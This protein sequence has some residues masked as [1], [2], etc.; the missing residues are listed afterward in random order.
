MDILKSIPLFMLIT[1]FPCVSAFLRHR[2][3]VYIQLTKRRK[4][5]AVEPGFDMFSAFLMHCIETRRFCVSLFLF[6]VSL[7]SF[8]FPEVASHEIAKNL[9]RNRIPLSLLVSLLFFLR[10]KNVEKKKRRRKKNRCLKPAAP[11]SAPSKSEEKWR[12][13]SS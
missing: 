10:E 1:S 6:H 9:K 11:M 8:V 2:F 4:L 12:A 5:H 3:Q 7:L 13:S